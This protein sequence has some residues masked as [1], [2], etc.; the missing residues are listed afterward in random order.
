MGFED[1]DYAWG[2]PSRRV[3][4]GGGNRAVKAIIAICAAIFVLQLLTQRAPQIYGEPPLRGLFGLDP[5]FLALGQVWRLVTYG[6]LHDEGQLLH[7]VFNMLWLWGL[8]QSVESRVGSREFVLFYL[9]AL[10]SGGLVFSALELIPAFSPG[11][12]AAT[13]TCVGASGAVMG[14]IMLSALWDPHRPISLIFITVPLW[15]IATVYGV[16]ETFAVLSRIGAGRVAADGVAHGAHF[17]GLLLGWAY[18]KLQWNFEGG[19]DRVTGRLP[20]FTFSGLKRS[21]GAGP[22]VR[23]HRP[24]AAEDDGDGDDLER[25]ADA[26]LAKLHASGESSLTR[27]ER[28]TLKLY[29][30]R[31]RAKRERG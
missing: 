15:L 16:I 21:V 30:E 9:A 22:K 25:R 10:L 29:S 7:I 11:A 26:V 13:A 18:Y 2:S 4:L 12:G 31:A 3:F 5:S 24:D 1:R 23:I 6:F 27:R 19:L 14:V 20:R 28:A 8:G 17:G